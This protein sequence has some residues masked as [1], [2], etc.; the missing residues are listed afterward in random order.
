MGALNRF[1]LSTDGFIERIEVTASAHSSTIIGKYYIQANTVD[2]NF[3]NAKP[4]TVSSLP[5]F[6]WLNNGYSYTKVF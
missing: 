5:C 1:E 6:P 4:N 2:D 3:T